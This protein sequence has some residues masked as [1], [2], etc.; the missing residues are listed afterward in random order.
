[1]RHNR[2]AMDSIRKNETFV[3][4]AVTHPIFLGIA[5]IVYKVILNFDIGLQVD[6][7]FL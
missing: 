1:M 6:K 5:W 3:I 7:P 2:F 4:G